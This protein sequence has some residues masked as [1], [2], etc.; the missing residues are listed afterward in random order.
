MWGVDSG[1]KCLSGVPVKETLMP[2]CLNCGSHVTERFCR[3]FGDN[4]DNIYRCFE[5]SE[6]RGEVFIPDNENFF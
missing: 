2:E 1:R 6:R 4:S 5:C 3:V